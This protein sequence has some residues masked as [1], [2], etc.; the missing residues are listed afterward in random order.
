MRLP[1]LLR[2]PALVLFIAFAATRADAGTVKISVALDTDSNAAT[3]CALATAGGTVQGIE[4]IATTVITTNA[5]GAV[6]TRLERQLCT[7]GSFGAPVVYDATGWNVGLGNGSGGS[8]VVETSIPLSMLPPG[9]AMR[10]L[11]TSDNGAG[12]Q[13]ATAAFALAL[14]PVAAPA[15]IVA[16]PLSPWLVPPLALLL[17]GAVLWLRRRYPGE[18]RLAL[19]VAALAVSGIAWAATVLRDVPAR[20][21]LPT[22]IDANDGESVV[23]RLRSSCWQ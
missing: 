7:A 15:P 23:I 20:R 22:S 9:A 13:D 4:Q 3:G 8:A 10:A 17:F 2:L 5:G 19:L 18:T 11:V 12:G 6:V 21:S 14:A 16:I 1:V